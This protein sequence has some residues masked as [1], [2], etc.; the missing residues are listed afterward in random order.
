[1]IN[2][3]VASKFAGSSN[4][5]RVRHLFSEYARSDPFA[6]VSAGGTPTLSALVRISSGPCQLC[7][8]QRRAEKFGERHFNTEPDTY[9]QAR[10]AP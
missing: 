8:I 1:M 5:I 6:A 10:E 9:N 2:A 4:Q 7:A 3:K